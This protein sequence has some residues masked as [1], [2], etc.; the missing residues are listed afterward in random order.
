[1]LLKGVTGAGVGA[2]VAFA[3]EPLE[4]ILVG[5]AG[6]VNV[7]GGVLAVHCRDLP[8]PVDLV[9]GRAGEV[10]AHGQFL[11]IG[12]GEGVGAVVVNAESPL[13]GVGKALELAVGQGHIGALVVVAGVLRGQSF[14]IG[15]VEY[16]H[17]VAIPQGGQ[18]CD[19]AALTGGGDLQPIDAGQQH[20][21]VGG[22]GVVQ[23]PGRLDVVQDAA[24][25]RIRAGHSGQ[26]AVVN[27]DGPCTGS[28][29]GVVQRLG[30]SGIDLLAV[31][32]GE[33]P[34]AGLA[35]QREDLHGVCRVSGVGFNTCEQLAG[36]AARSVGLA[37]GR[38][39][40]NDLVAG[41]QRGGVRYQR[42]LRRCVCKHR[43]GQQRQQH[44]QCQQHG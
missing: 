21:H 37:V 43:C 42:C 34:L 44:H 2:P 7:E 40:E 26:S 11:A 38:R 36:Q 30:I 39:R 19:D 23:E 16:D 28:L 1:M 25:G 41:F 4:T 6:V 20:A 12:G 35:A 5:A 32:R 22:R 33:R 17:L 14:P 29:A 31:G 3:R 15:G 9:Q 10:C 24:A 13:I 8:V 18:V 27:G